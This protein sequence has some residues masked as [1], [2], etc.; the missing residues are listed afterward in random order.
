MSTPIKITN[1]VFAGDLHLRQQ[2]WNTRPELAGDSYESFI[3][4]IEYCVQ[5]NSSLI[6][7]GDIFNSINPD[8]RSVEVLRRG[9]DTM[10]QSALPVYVIQGQ[11]DRANPPWPLALVD[12]PMVMYVADKLFVPI[13]CGPI[14]YAIDQTPVAADLKAKLAN[15]PDKVKVLVLHQLAKDVFPIEG[16]YDF[17]SEWV[18]KHVQT[19]LMADYHKR[20]TFKW[21]GT[22]VGRYCGSTYM[23]KIDEEPDKSFYSL[24]INENGDLQTAV[25]PLRTRPYKF[26]V[27]NDEAELTK[28]SESLAAIPKAT[29]MLPVVVVTYVATVPDVEVKLRAVLE[30]KAYLWLRPVT[31]RTVWTAE[32]GAVADVPRQRLTLENCVSKFLTPDSDEHKLLMALLAADNPEEVLAIWRLNKRVA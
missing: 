28:C 11:H 7:A 29:G 1:C 15:V 17:D 25:I 6:L 8:A 23:C 2:A 13:T 22:K 16:A 18:P 24:T 20:C 31:M 10:A 14:F 5:H 32:E 12:N 19:L 30:K 21:Q 27:I 4:I 26:L 3:Q 9:L